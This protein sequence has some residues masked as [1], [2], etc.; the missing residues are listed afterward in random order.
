DARRLARLTKLLIAERVIGD[1][2]ARALHLVHDFVARIDAERALDTFK[3]HPVANI[4]AHWAGSHALAA[5]DA[6]AAAFP[7]RALLV[8]SA[9]FAPVGAVADEKRILVEH[10]ALNTRPGAHIDADLLARDGAEKIGGEGK[11]CNE[12]PGNKRRFKAEKLRGKRWRI[13]E[14]EDPCAARRNGDEKPDN[15]LADL[16]HD[17]VEA[18]GRF[19]EADARRAISFKEALHMKEE[20]GPHRLRAGIA[21]PDAASDAC[22]QK[23]AKRRQNEQP[24]DVVEFLRPDFEKE[25][26]ETAR[27]KIEQHGLIGQAGPAL[28]AQPRRHII[29]GERHRHDEPFE[30]AEGAAHQLRIDFYPALIKRAVLFRIDGCVALPFLA[31]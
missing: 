4:D 23:Q 22:D 6:V 13:G 2:A 28:P 15:V 24:R 14:V 31:M 11:K 17:L 10:G 30:A 5:I 18:Q 3:L 12:E 1:E 29:D 9:L 26:V 19:V 16:A 7:A 27:G 20:I 21:A 25:E 8:R